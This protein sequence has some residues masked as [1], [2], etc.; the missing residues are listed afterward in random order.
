MSDIRVAFITVAQQVARL[1]QP[2][3]VKVTLGR[4]PGSLLKLAV[5]G[6]Q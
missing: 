1:Y 3:S 4:L 5:Q 6:A 2:Q